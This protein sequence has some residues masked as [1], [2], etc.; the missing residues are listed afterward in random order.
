MQQAINIYLAQ[1]AVGAQGLYYREQVVQLLNPNLEM[2][3][4]GPSG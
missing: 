2:L 3:F 1:K 4:S